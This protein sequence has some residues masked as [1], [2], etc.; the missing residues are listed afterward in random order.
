MPSEEAFYL[1]PMRTTSCQTQKVVDQQEIKKFEI[2]QFGANGS[3]NSW[4]GK[5]SSTSEDCLFVCLFRKIPGNKSIRIICT[6]FSWSDQNFF[7]NQWKVPLL[8]K[9]VKVEICF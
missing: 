9:A 5:K 8:S 1:S 6:D 7:L 3:E 2:Y 4:N